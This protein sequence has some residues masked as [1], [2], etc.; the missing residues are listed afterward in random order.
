VAN[1][2]NKYAKG[3]NALGMCER[4]SKKTL[5]RLLRYDGY[6]NDLLVCKDCWDPYHPQERLPDVTDPVSLYDP[7]GDPD[8][9]QASVSVIPW[10]PWQP[11]TAHG[12][13]TPTGGFS[14][15]PNIVRD[16][17]IRTPMSIGVTLGSSRFTT[18]NLEAP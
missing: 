4:C 17:P 2:T 14:T 11:L 3:L 6:Y 16:T 18:T 9:A 13:G 7:T 10:P 12:M 15:A 8:K 1:G 5:L